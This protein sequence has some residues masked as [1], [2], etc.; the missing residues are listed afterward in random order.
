MRVINFCVDIITD[1]KAVLF[2]KTKKKK[3]KKKKEKK[4]GVC[5]IRDGRIDM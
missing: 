4:E 1:S 2:V 5:Q 3:K